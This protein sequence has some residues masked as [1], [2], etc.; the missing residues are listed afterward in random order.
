MC[1]LKNG[2][3][4]QSA[5]HFFL[6]IKISVHT[7]RPRLN[8]CR[9]TCSDECVTLNVEFCAGYAGVMICKQETTS[10]VE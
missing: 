10:S 2:S 3:G 6:L 9:N 8:S 4:A 7:S 5:S 1:M